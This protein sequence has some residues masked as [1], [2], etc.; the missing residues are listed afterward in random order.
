M[1]VAELLHLR[2]AN[3]RELDELCSKLENRRLRKLPGATMA[4]FAAL[5]RSVCADLAL[6]EAYQLPPNTVSYLHRLVGRAH[7]QLYRSRTFNFAE[8]K[9]HLLEKV[10]QQL[11]SDRSLWLAF[12]LFWSVFLLSMLLGAEVKVPILE[13]PLMRGFA[14]RVV[15]EADLSHH[16]QHFEGHPFGTSG[17]LSVDWASGYFV[18]NTGIGLRCF[19]MGLVF[20][21]GGLFAIVFNA[22]YL[23]AF[24]GY[25][26][27][28]DS[29]RDNFLEFVTAHGPFELTAIVLS[30]AAGMRV[31]FALVSTGGRTRMESLQAAVREAVP[32]IVAAAI[33][34]TLAACIEGFLSPS[35]LPYGFKVIVG[36]ISAALLVT[37]FVLLGWP[38][39]AT[40]GGELDSDVGNPSEGKEIGPL[41]IVKTS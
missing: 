1:K 30:A 23:G 2:R 24:F 4:R 39:P 27:R 35:D 17:D 19:A 14:E 12:S 6:A 25:M 16:R 22:A 26:I 5:Y 28:C 41:K 3:W 40:V 8:L 9:R 20:G 18:H 13:R 21:V 37:Y 38:R 34:F 15:G 33:L 36:A 31:G 29:A 32:T 10:P 7:N 11:F